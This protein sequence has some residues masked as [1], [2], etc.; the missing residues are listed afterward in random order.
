MRRRLSPIT[1]RKAARIPS[2]QRQIDQGGWCWVCGFGYVPESPE[3][4]RMHSRFHAEY[5]RPRLPKPDPRLAGFAGDVRVDAASPRWLH[6]LVYERARAL[7]RDLQ[8]TGGAQWGKH[9]PHEPDPNECGQH[10]ILL[11]EAPTVP[12][13][14]VSLAWFDWPSGGDRLQP[15]PGWHMLFAWVADSWRRQGVLSRRWPVWRA[16][17]GEFTLEPPLSEAMQAFVGKMGPRCGSPAGDRSDPNFSQFLTR[18]RT[19]QGTR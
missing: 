19:W 16:R 18:L 2:L 11:V 4:R 12:V 14:A 6:K 7:Q 8:L 9:G 17:Y 13:G 3:D 10:A 15:P 1:D 5:I